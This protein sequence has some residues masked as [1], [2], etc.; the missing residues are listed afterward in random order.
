M[1]VRPEL[2]IYINRRRFG[3]ASGVGGLM[4]GQQIAG[5]AGVPADNAVVEAQTESGG[6][7]EV[8]MDHNVHLT[9][10]MHFLVTRQYV[11]GG[12]P[13]AS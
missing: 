2:H 4:T 5:L 10:G 9:P 3:V 1:Q 8:G 11:M 7:L 6:L 13:P 12:R